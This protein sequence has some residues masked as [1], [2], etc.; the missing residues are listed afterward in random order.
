M[1][2]SADGSMASWAEKSPAN[3]NKLPQ[4][5]MQLCECSEL[6]RVDELESRQVVDLTQVNYFQFAM[7]PGYFL[8]IKE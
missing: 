8:W 4:L 2:K 1:I 3:G 7:G 6:A 5:L